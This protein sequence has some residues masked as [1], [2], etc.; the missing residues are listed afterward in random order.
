[1]RDLDEW[2]PLEDGEREISPTLIMTGRGEPPSHEPTGSDGS[3]ATVSS[4]SEDATGS[5][6]CLLTKV[7]ET[8]EILVQLGDE[9]DAPDAVEPE[10]QPAMPEEGLY[11][12]ARHGTV[13]RGNPGDWTRLSR[14]RAIPFHGDERYRRVSAWPAHSA[15]SCSRYFPEG[16]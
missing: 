6:D 2:K 1:M 14:D 8:Q 16:I 3:T 9:D 11:R 4:S 7:A 5:S 13:H 15:L 10:D 12:H